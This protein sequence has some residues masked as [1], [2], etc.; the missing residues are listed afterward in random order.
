ME[1]F[2]STSFMPHLGH[3]PGFALWTSGCIGQVYVVE[4]AVAAAVAGALAGTLEGAVEGASPGVME[5]VEGAS[6][7]PVGAEEPSFP[8]WS[9]FLSPPDSI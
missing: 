4:G 7:L 3:D 9:G 1:T 5:V 2:F 6:F 8:C